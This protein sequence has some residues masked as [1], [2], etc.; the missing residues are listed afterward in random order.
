MDVSKYVAARGADEAASLM[1]RAG[2]AAP[3]IDHGLAVGVGVI[4]RRAR[5]NSTLLRADARRF[6]C[7]V[8][9]FVMS[10]F[11]LRSRCSSAASR[12]VCDFRE[13]NISPSQAGEGV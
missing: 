4:A 9:T 7:N 13:Y 11:T 1:P 10:A 12:S 3:I 5:P 2:D 6:R 8:N